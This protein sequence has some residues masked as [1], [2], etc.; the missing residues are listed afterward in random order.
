MSNSPDPGLREPRVGYWLGSI[1]CLQGRIFIISFN[2]DSDCCSLSY[3]SGGEG[4]VS[5]LLL[6]KTWAPKTAV[7]HSAE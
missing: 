7:V 5:P 6:P 4:E 1:K 2:L 3:P